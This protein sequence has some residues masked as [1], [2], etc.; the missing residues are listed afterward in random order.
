[1]WDA[2]GYVSEAI[3]ELAKWLGF[4][5]KKEVLITEAHFKMTEKVFKKP[6]F[7]A[8]YEE[9]VENELLDRLKMGGNSNSS[10]NFDE[11]TPA[12][13]KRAP[14]RQPRQTKKKES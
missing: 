1:M 12:V 2:L 13:T 9:V 14:K 5:V 3:A 7:V 6:T 8:N 4:F 10:F 11:P